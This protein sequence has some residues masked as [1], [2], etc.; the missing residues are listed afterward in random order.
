MEIKLQ[1]E[2]AAAR[3]ERELLESVVP[4]WEKHSIDRECGG[5]FN[6]LTRDGKVFDNEKSMWMQWRMVYMF[7]T[8][9]ASEYRQDRWLELSRH[10]YEFLTQHGKDQH[11][12]YYFSLNRKGEPMVAAYNIYSDCFAAMGAA[13]LFKATGETKYRKE[14]ELSMSHYLSRVDNPKGKWEKSMPGKPKRKTLGHY[15]MMANLGYVLNECLG[16]EQYEAD[17]RRAADTVLDMF[18]NPELDLLFENVNLDGSV[19]LESCDGRHINP[20]HGLEA[21]WFLLQYA[22]RTGDRRLAAKACYVVKSLLEFGWDPVH[23]GLFYF[24]DA[25]GLPHAELQWDMKLW[26]VH[27]EA[28]LASLFAYEASRDSNFLDWFQRLDEWTW[29]R[30]PDP[31]HGEWYAYL[32]RHGE[33]THTL[34]GGRWKCFFHLPRCLLFGTRLMRGSEMK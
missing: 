5:Y 15:M 9:Y 8:L 33:P 10:G 22:R 7:A 24:M 19:D 28:I 34:K 6:F 25:K 29:R 32:N 21:M 17:I 20:G 18:W 30:F 14:A 4:F 3:Y 16:T 26:W 23:G 12:N 1:L 31:E 2:K 27:N 13:A 11:G